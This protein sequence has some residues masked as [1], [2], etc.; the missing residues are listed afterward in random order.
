M[1]LV[2]AL[3]FGITLFSTIISAVPTREIANKGLFVAKVVGGGA[4]L[5]G[6]GLIVYYVNRRDAAALPPVV[7]PEDGESWISGGS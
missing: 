4:L 7:T 5:I 2:A 6:A 1:W 3:G